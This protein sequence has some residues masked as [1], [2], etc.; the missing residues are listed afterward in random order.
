MVIIPTNIE[1]QDASS[2]SFYPN[3]ANTSIIITADAALLNC[4]YRIT[5]SQG[6][7]VKAGALQ[8][9]TTTLDVTSL[10]SG[11][12]TVGVTSDARVLTQTLIIQK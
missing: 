10:A 4:P 11:K 5:D 6:K 9:A 3:P 12:Y 2:F 8:G 1:E 7:L